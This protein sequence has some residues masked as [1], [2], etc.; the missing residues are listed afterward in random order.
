MGWKNKRSNKYLVRNRPNYQQPGHSDP[1][2]IPGTL[3]WTKIHWELVDVWLLGSEYLQTWISWSVRTCKNSITVTQKPKWCSLDVQC[4]LKPYRESDCFLWFW[5]CHSLINVEHRWTA[6]PAGVVQR[7]IW[8][9]FLCID[10]KTIPADNADLSS[11]ACTF[12]LSPFDPSEPRF[13][14][15]TAGSVCHNSIS[16]SVNLSASENSFHFSLTRSNESFSSLFR[17]V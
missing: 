11:V 3:R 8:L 12:L 10:G 14:T 9:N 5:F 15:L 16:F 1:W 2:G 6:C 4:D 7:C 13:S 17:S